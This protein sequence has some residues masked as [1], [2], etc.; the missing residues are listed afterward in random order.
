MKKIELD[1]FYQ[2]RYLGNVAYSPNGKRL[3]FTVSKANIKTNGYDH[4]LYLYEDGDYRQLTFT[5]KESSFIWDDDDTLLFASMR[6]EEDQK[7]SEEQPL[8]VYYRL[9]LKGGEAHRAFALPL[10][11]GK[12]EKVAPQQYLFCASHHTRFETFGKSEAQAKESFAAM[13]A[14]K[15]YEVLEDLP[16]YF[17]GAGFIDAKRTGLFLYDESRD[18]CEAIIYDKTMQVNDFVLNTDHTKVAIVVNHQVHCTSEHDAILLY[19]LK[20]KRLETILKGDRFLIHDINFLNDQV[21]FAGTEGKRY[22][23]NENPDF[24]QIDLATHT[25]SL[26]A[27][28]GESIGNSVGS[29]CRLG[30][31]QATMVKDD[32]YYFLTTRLHSSVIYALDKTGAIRPYLDLEG[33]CDCFDIGKE[34]L[35]CV[36][37]YDM[38]LQEL[39]RYQEGTLKQLTHF[40]DWMSEYATCSLHSY[41]INSDDVAIHG[42]VMLPP[43]FDESKRYPAILDIHGGPKTVYGPVFYHEMQAWANA[44]YIVFFLNPRGGDG[45]GNTFMDIRGK[46]GTIDYDD[47]MRF[48]D[49]VLDTYPQIDQTRMAVTGGS[50]GG[51]MTNWII[52][53]TDRFAAAASQRSI[54]NW[55]SFEN[56][57]DIGMRFAK[58]QQQATAWDNMEKLWFHSPLAYADHVKTPTLFIHSDCDYRCPI[59]EGYQMY[60]ALKAFGVDSRLCLFHGENHELSRSG[61]PLH[62]LRR[63]QEITDWITKYTAEKK[64]TD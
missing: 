47:I 14:D 30:G 57:S 59:S 33:S 34:G 23:L 9:P 55:I 27:E 32:V 2:Y 61:K 1:T 28:Y 5:G 18:T 60:S 8:T 62:R 48:C 40:H 53:H 13:Q 42:W 50:Y 16:F 36:G 56:T 21:L 11:A 35:V 17:N 39:Y 20:E 15:D 45:R 54:A 58:D 24:Y 64:E 25:C 46:Y 43:D 63:L 19:D 29:D 44:G 52:T 38:K 4:D 22:G 41:T 3:A 26:F 49:F 31:G 51:F 7:K 6:L 12:M 37:M 10:Q